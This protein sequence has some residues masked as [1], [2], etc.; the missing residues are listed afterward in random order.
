M[1]NDELG[2]LSVPARGG[3][4]RGGIRFV[5]FALSSAQVSIE[6]SAHFTP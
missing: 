6:H 1:T 2:A 3:V 4:V 5:I